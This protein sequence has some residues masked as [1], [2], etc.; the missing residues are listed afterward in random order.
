[1]DN[2]TYKAAGVN[3][4]AADAM[5][6]Q[7]SADV[8]SRGLA[9]CAPLNRVGAF[10]SLVSLDLSSYKNPI[11]V[12]KTEEPGS[13]QMLSIDND[14]IEWIA[15]DLINHLVND[16]IV[17]GVTPCAVLDTIIC[18]KME[19]DKVLRLVRAMSAACLENGCI[20]V[21]GETSEQP[22]VLPAG[23]YILQ[24]SILGIVDKDKI[25]DGAG[26][27][28]GDALL[29]LASNGLHTNGYSLV[30]KLMETKPAIMDE[31]IGGEKFIDAILAP[32]TSYAVSVKSL[33]ENRSGDIHGMAHITGGGMRDNLARILRG[34]ARA[35]IDLSAVRI[36]RVFGVIRKYANAGDDDMLRTFNNGVGMILVVDGAAAG[37]VE[38][39]LLD[40]GTE[41]YRIGRITGAPEGSSSEG[42]ESAP[43]EVVYHNTLHWDS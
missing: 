34:G 36:P 25:I 23:R 40:I 6:K 35:E 13:K 10:A 42:G 7:L 31:S 39:S 41:A 16:I 3:I 2:I 4:D 24:A 15:R 19:G 37:E 5:K 22:G 29:A 9:H 18:G 12:L 20:L 38:K 43:G 33:V 17:M 21:G 11:F 28:N 26:I 32:H 30:R 14:R 1:M 27:K 8:S